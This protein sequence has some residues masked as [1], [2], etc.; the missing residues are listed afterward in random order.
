MLRETM[1]YL[2]IRDLCMCKL[3]ISG[4]TLERNVRCSRHPG[5]FWGSVQ[6][7]YSWNRAGGKQTCHSEK[8]YNFLSY[9]PLFL[10][11]GWGEVKGIAPGK[12]PRPGVG[13]GLGLGCILAPDRV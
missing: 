11:V 7:L 4:R 5:C 9:S 8:K 12:S 1:I 6:W 2:V 3:W 13:V 10:W